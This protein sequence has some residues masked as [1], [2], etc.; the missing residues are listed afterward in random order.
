MRPKRRSDPGF[1][2]SPNGFGSR[3]L[4]HQ[5]GPDPVFL[6]TKQVRILFFSP[7]GFRSR[8]LFHQAGPDPGFCSPSGSDPGVPQP[9]PGLRH[10]VPHLRGHV[11]P[12]WAIRAIFSYSFLCSAGLHNTGKPLTFAGWEHLQTGNCGTPR[13]LARHAGGADQELSQTI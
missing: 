4:V 7:N 11:V 1:V 9:P 2:F 8:L 6:F 12:G 13:T 5:A 10:P 3:F